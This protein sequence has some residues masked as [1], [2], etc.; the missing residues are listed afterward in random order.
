MLAVFGLAA[1]LLV[2]VP[3]DTPPPAPTVSRPRPRAIEVSEWYNRRL[4]IHRWLAYTSLPVF[5]FQYAAGRQ[6]WAK[7]PSAPAWARTG[8]RVGATTLAAIFTVNTVTGMWN[9]WDSRHVPQNRGLRYMHA[10]SM[11]TADAG[12]T[13]A[14]AVLS[15]QA[16]RDFN[17]RRLHRTVALTSM[18][19]TVTSSVL[20]KV[21]NK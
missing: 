17:K 3:S 21:L 8:H 15:E 11:L 19:I 4:T 5:G 18:G 7:G 20:M 9:L 14:G 1:Q 6:L 16:E 12:F 13:W 2:A 10:L